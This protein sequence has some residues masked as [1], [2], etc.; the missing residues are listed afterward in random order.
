MN[1]TAEQQSAGR[2][3]RWLPGAGDRRHLGEQLQGAGGVAGGKQQGG[4]AV[5]GSVNLV[6]VGVFL[7]D[8]LQDPGGLLRS[9]SRGIISRSLQERPGRCFAGG[10]TLLDFLEAAS[11]FQIATFHL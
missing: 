1:G 6:V 8:P 3:R 5:A 11:R 2:F 10:V 4:Q 7:D 9:S